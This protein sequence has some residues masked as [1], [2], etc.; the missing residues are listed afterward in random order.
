MCLD[1]KSLLMT[2]RGWMQLS[3]LAKEKSS[4]TIGYDG[5]TIEKD[6]RIYKYQGAKVF[7]TADKAPVHRIRFHKG[8]SII[9]TEDQEMLVRNT[10]G[11]LI[12]KSFR[13]LKVHSEISIPCNIG[14]FGKK[15]SPGDMVGSIEA[16]CNF[17]ESIFAK[18]WSEKGSSFYECESD[19]IL[20]RVQM[21][22]TSF[23]CESE[24]V[25]PYDMGTPGL[26]MSQYK[27]LKII[28]NQ[29]EILKKN[30]DKVRKGDKDFI[31][32]K[33]QAFSTIKQIELL[34]RRPVYNLQK[35]ANLPI[36]VNGIN[37]I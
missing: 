1:G 22:L 8:Q 21:L 27:R 35:P 32:R 18:N 33:K 36:I 4:I 31:T 16:T 17:M 6:S 37:I 5:T 15:P 2:T 34:D 12:A 14:L 13:D 29:K 30:I 10:K 24:I 20:M 3:I 7:K 25:N 23:G 26:T 9:V 11:K 19:L 28:N